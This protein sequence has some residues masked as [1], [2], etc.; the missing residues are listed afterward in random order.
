MELFKNEVL[1]FYPVKEI[2]N[3]DKKYLYNIKTAA[4]FETDDATIELVKSKNLTYSDA[5]K[6]FKK[7]W[8]KEQLDKLLQDME[9][10]LILK[11]DKNEKK[12]RDLHENKIYTHS[13]KLSGIVLFVIQEC[14]LRCTYCYGDGGEYNHKGILKWDTAKKSIDFLFEQSGDNKDISITF[15]GGEPLMNFSIIEKCVE[16]SKKVNKNFNKKL[17]FSITTN[18]TLLTDK[19][20]KFLI[21]NDFSIVISVDGGKEVHD[22]NRFFANGKGTFDT[23]VERSK[24]LIEN[25]SVA[26]R[27]TIN[28]KNMDLVK[29]FGDLY[30]LGFKKI[31]MSP[32]T[33][34][35]SDKDYDTLANSYCNLINE[36]DEVLKI[37]KKRAS[38]MRDI[39]GI[40]SQIESGGIRSKSCGAGTNTIAVNVDGE[41]F[42]C[43]RFVNMQDYSLGNINV[44]FDVEKYESIISDMYIDTHEECSECWASNLCGGGCANQNVIENGSIK[45]PITNICNMNKKFYESAIQYYVSTIEK[46]VID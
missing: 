10:S 41:M 35:L 40:L 42:L 34:L 6:Y 22:T 30:D 24:Y 27:A 20:T 33:E 19:I 3:K 31:T 21:D 36:Y 46:P 39:D 43:H 8:D 1:E 25:T 13:P 45:K 16:Y 23:L 9:N 7:H 5:V 14:N 2:I 44:G 11:N 12:I 17:Y 32:C 29:T 15:F 4:L 28:N 18:G 26:A 37:D 38:A